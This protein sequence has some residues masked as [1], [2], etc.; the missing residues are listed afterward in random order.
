MALVLD[1]LGDD[2]DPGYGLVRRH[3]RVRPQSLRDWTSSLWAIIV[4]AA[5][6]VVLGIA[7]AQA[8]SAAPDVAAARA[9]LIERVR[10]LNQEN[11]DLRVRIDDER[12]ALAE[13]QGA[14]LV[15]NDRAESILSQSG[16][17]ALTGGYRRVSGP[18]V[19]ITLRDPPA[20][21]VLPADADPALARILDADLQD[22]VN[23]LWAAGAEAVA[24]NNQRLATTTAIRQAG[25]A[26]LVGY[27]PVLAPYR[28]R[29]IG[30]PDLADRF[31]RQPVN[32]QLSALNADYGIGVTIVPGRFLALPGASVPTLA[33][34]RT[35]PAP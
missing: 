29:A 18:G 12:T 34:A 25:S 19:T 23:G 2:G 11:R 27:R 9:D 13:A 35:M 10:A 22:V 20:S 5:V 26:I 31:T 8:R 32:E 6:G 14:L 33:Y 21:A 7:L 28:V 24:I 15:G 16:S 3:L 17:L 1:I 30:P 4:I